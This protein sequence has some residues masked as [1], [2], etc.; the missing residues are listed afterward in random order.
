MLTKL[1]N[2]VD[3]LQATTSSNEKK[4]ILIQHSHLRKLLSLIYS[5]FNQFGVTSEN[6]LKLKGTLNVEGIHCNDLVELLTAL[7]KRIV[8]GHEA[9]Q[10]VQ[11]FIDN[12]FTYQYLILNAIDK[13]LK[14]RIDVALINSVFPD[15]IPTFNVA[16]ARDISKVSKKP[17]F[18]YE[19]WYGSRKLDGVRCVIIKQA[20]MKTMAYSRTGKEYLTLD[21][22]I[23]DIDRLPGTNMIFDGEICLVDA[24]G[25]EDFQ[26]IM[27][28]IRRKDHTIENPKFHIFDM[29]PLIDFLDQKSGIRLMYRFRCLHTVFAEAEEDTP[30]LKILEQELLTSEAMFDELVNKAS[31]LGWEGIMLRKNTDYEGKR[32][33]NLLKVKKF[34][35]AEYV[36]KGI[37]SGP[38]RVFENGV[39]VELNVMTRAIIEHRGFSVGVGSGWNMEQRIAF[40]QDPSLIIGQVA[41]IKYFEETRN[42]DGGISLRFPTLKALH[43]AKRES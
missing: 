5:D 21:K 28:E 17:D 33:N 26:G 35:D 32:S 25:K 43:G 1:Q 11:R 6:V 10:T 14:C 4:A 38:M 42:Q 30:T 18:E 3:E 39:E 36:I 7:S 41:T 27:K 2:L 13:N 16:L 15:C 37:E 12:N 20:G 23:A 24:N 8:T 22:V 34:F 29:V 9:I 40:E 19:M 31:N